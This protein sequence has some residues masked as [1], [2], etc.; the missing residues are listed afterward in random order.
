M[1]SQQSVVQDRRLVQVGAFLQ[2]GRLEEGRECLFHLVHRVLEIQNEGAILAGMGPV[3][4]SEGLDRLQP[5]E[6]FVDI[7]RDE[8]W[9]IEPGLI[10]LGDDKD[11]ILARVELS[12]QFRF[13][14]S[15]CSRLGPDIAIDVQIARERHQRLEIGV[16]LV[17]DIAV[18]LL[19]VTQGMFATLRN[20]HRF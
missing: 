19:P 18:Q 3:Q 7:H 9:L 11:L 17:F 13:G 15:V 16:S 8:F 14:E 1:S 12:G 10:L 2:C 6:L 5:G 4:S 20:D